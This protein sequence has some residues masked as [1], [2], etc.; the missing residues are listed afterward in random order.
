MHVATLEGKVADVMGSS[1]RADSIRKADPAKELLLSV[2]VH[3]HRLSDTKTTRC[4][5]RL[6]HK[7]KISLGQFAGLTLAK[8]PFTF[9]W[10]ARHVY[11]S[12]SGTRLNVYRIALFKPARTC[13][14]AADPVVAMPR[15]DVQLPLS[16]TGR[17]VYYLEE[18]VIGG[19]RKTGRAMVVMG[20]YGGP[21][22]RVQLKA[23]STNALRLGLG[24]IETKEPLPYPCPPVGFFLDVEKDLGGWV[25]PAGKVKVELDGDG[26]IPGG[27]LLRK[28]EYF[29]D[30]DDV[31]LEA[32][33][34][35]CF[36]PLRW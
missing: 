1:Q 31:D 26:R 29:N 30:Q 2:F 17:Q 5:P 32:I 28:I 13:C 8:L 11:V 9:T 24:D 33:C 34:D 15:L 22:S 4:P 23:R 21:Q 25:A 7:A 35:V 16:A 6:V 20:S 10:T 36:M 14:D 3:T 27:K 19:N 18:E 12:I